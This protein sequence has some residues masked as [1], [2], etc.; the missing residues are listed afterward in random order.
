MNCIAKI[1]E[2]ENH[3]TGKHTI[4]AWYFNSH[5]YCES[6]EEAYAYIRERLLRSDEPDCLCLM[7]YICITKKMEVKYENELVIEAGA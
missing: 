7:R 4:D 6:F 5:K 2:T 1:I 3:K